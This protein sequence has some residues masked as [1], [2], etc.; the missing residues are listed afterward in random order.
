[1]SPRLTFL[2][3]FLQNRIAIAAVDKRISV[4]N[5]MNIKP[6]KVAMSSLLNK[7]HSKV[8][9]IA[10]HPTKE[11]ILAFGTH[12]GQVGFIDTNS[13]TNI[14]IRMKPYFSQAVYSLSWGHIPPINNATE[15]RLVLFACSDSKLVYF[16]GTGEQKHEA[17]PVCVTYDVTEI[18]CC[19]NILAV[20]TKSGSLYLCDLDNNF[21]VIYNEE[22]SSRKQYVSSISWNTINKNLLA[23][24]SMDKDIRI[25]NRLN[26]EE[27]KTLRGH[28]AGVA[29]IRWSPNS[30]NKLVSASFDN[31]VRVWDIN[32]QLVISLYKFDNCMFAAMFSP[33]DD[34]FIIC[35]GKDV[36]FNIYDSRLHNDDAS[37]PAEN[38]KMQLSSII[39]QHGPKLKKKKKTK[40]IP[41][42]PQ[43]GEE[44][45]TT[46]FHEL[47][48]D[49]KGG[50]KVTAPIQAAT[51]S[52]DLNGSYSTT[53]MYLTS[54]E[55]NSNPT[56]T[57]MSVID[58]IS[59]DK[60]I[61]HEKLFSRS[62]SDVEYV[63][64]LESE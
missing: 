16:P 14:P 58:R 32:T 38:V 1:M 36:S 21:D 26:K 42:L 47:K 20:G 8:L 41:N 52:S 4:T 10:W 54:K 44:E 34:N 9:S 50:G 49:S 25:I 43:V 29:S 39:M 15:K 46:A 48:V 2:K 61:L 23:S 28:T 51:V 5:V 37:I 19:D 33:I 30:I 18:S 45:L 64:D 13:S 53:V 24:A 11:N 60:E 6:N 12:E 31:T 27:N 17:H 3:I 22:I 35:A 59:E 7:I 55:L 63:L 57:I 62:R 40:T 56:L